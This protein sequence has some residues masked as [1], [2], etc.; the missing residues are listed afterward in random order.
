MTPLPYAIEV[1]T[2]I[3]NLVGTDTLA[4]SLLFFSPFGWRLAH[5]G[6]DG[7]IHHVCLCLGF[8]CSAVCD[9]GVR[10][11]P[12][13]IS[14]FK[15]WALYLCIEVRTTNDDDST[16]QRASTSCL[17][18]TCAEMQVL[19]DEVKFALTCQ[20]EQNEAAI[21]GNGHSIFPMSY[22]MTKVP[23]A[24]HEDAK[25]LIERHEIIH[26]WTVD[27]T[28]IAEGIASLDLHV[29]VEE[30]VK[31]LDDQYI[32]ENGRFMGRGFA[33]QAAMKALQEWVDKGDDLPKRQKRKLGNE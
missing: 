25:E 21:N 33:A 24:W 23:S 29:F 20:P 30:K 16:T 3:G 13:A 5:L 15:V 22:Y 14:C 26:G 27:G 4:T 10:T 7:V 18:M 2:R 8:Q 17:P 12:A 1:H 28:G 32:C 19:R 31:Q 11:A 6:R 9:L